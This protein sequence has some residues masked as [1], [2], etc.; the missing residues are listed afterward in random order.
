MK[1]NGFTLAETLVAMTIIG[2]IAAI[3][4]P[5]INNFKPNE[6]KMLFLKVYDSMV[7]TT[8]MLVDNQNIYPIYDVANDRN[9]LGSPLANTEQITFNNKSYGGDHKKYCE[10]LAMA[11]TD[12]SEV[13]CSDGDRIKVTD[14]WSTTPSFISTLNGVTFFVNT[15]YLLDEENNTVT[16]QTDVFFDVN[17]INK[18][19]DCIYNVKTCPFPDRFKLIVSADGNVSPADPKGRIYL[20]NRANYKLNKDETEEGGFIDSL[21]DN[22]KK[23]Q[24]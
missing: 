23:R 4:L 19:V 13:N 20:N 14:I 11:F 8:Q 17:G 6:N 21:E 16:Y 22:K 24:L 2:V 1:K 10:L 15:E 12:E 18:G 3:T 5:L 7:E 9:Y